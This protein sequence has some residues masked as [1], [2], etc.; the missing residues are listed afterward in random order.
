MNEHFDLCT[1]WKSRCLQI[2][3]QLDATIV[4]V[5]ATANQIYHTSVG[6]RSDAIDCGVKLHIK[7]SR[8]LKVWSRVLRKNE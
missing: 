5:T 4:D 2:L 7:V 8:K 3:M 1:Q 6:S